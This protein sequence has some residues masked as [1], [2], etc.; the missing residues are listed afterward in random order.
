MGIGIASKSHKTRRDRRGSTESL[1]AGVLVCQLNAKISG[2]TYFP[3]RDE[4]I[5]T[6]T[7]L[8][9]GMQFNAC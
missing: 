5:V 9:D 6:P 8:Q 3:E 7:I 4:E 1:H 2:H